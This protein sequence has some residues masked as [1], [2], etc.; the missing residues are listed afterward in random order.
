MVAYIMYVSLLENASCKKLWIIYS[1]S[2]ITDVIAEIIFL[3]VGG[4]YVY[5]GNQPLVIIGEPV[6]LPLWWM[7]MNNAGLFPGIAI[8]F[9]FRDKLKGWKN[10]LVLPLLP[11]CYLGVNSAVSMTTAFAINSGSMSWIA[12]QIIGIITC[13][14]CICVVK[15]TMIV[16]LN[17]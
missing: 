15:G 12:T 6:N 11:L 8:T 2:V 14:L 10:F 16:V 1:I 7:F 5:Y 13:A 3:G 17:K 4:L 9:R